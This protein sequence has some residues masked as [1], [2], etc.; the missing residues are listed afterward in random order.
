MIRAKHD[1]FGAVLPWF[2]MLAILAGQLGCDDD[3]YT[4]SNT[5]PVAGTTK[6]IAAGSDP[7]VAVDA[8]GNLHLVYVRDGFVL[9]AKFNYSTDTFMIPETVVGGGDDPQVAVDSLGNP[10]VVFGNV[11]YAAWNGAGFSVPVSYI[12]GRGR[13]R[14]AIDTMDRVYT[15]GMRVSGPRVKLFMFQNNTMLLNGIVVGKNDLGGIDVDDTGRVHVCWRSGRELYYSTYMEGEDTTGI[16][17][18]SVFISGYASD[19]SDIAVD[20]RDGTLHVTHTHSYG[21]KIDYLYRGADGVWS[22]DTSHAAGQCLDA[23]DFTQPTIAVDRDGYKYIVFTG[24]HYVPKY[25]VI[26]RDGTEIV[27]TTDIDQALA[28][29]KKKNPNVASR[30]NMS[31]AYVAWGQGSVYVRPLGAISF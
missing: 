26:G 18:R 19:F 7:D 21:G 20:H 24:D 2:L 23:A 3:T 4:L 12:D 10:H 13:P 16:A 11:F 6:Y 28:G 27:G 30:R 8:Q 15:S 17:D 9:Y 14:I 29:A 31:G 1:R 25:F 5:P 22:S